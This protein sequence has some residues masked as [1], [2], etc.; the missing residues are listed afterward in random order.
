MS[1]RGAIV[2]VLALLVLAGCTSTAP[3]RER[4]KGALQSSRTTTD[5]LTR[6]T[7]PVVVAVGDIAC[8]PGDRVT[9]D[10]CRHARTARLA[11]SFDPDRLLLLGDL[12]YDSGT[13]AEFRRSYAS[14]W[15]EMRA[16]SRPVPGN[17]EYHTP[18]AE[19]YFYYFRN[20]VPSHPGYYVFRVGSW[21]VFALNSNC[22]V[23]DCERQQRWLNR[24]MARRATRCSAV[25]MHHPRY[26]SG[27][28]HGSTTV[29]RP[30]WKV[31]LD[32]RTD[33][34]LAGHDHG[35]ERFRRMNANGGVVRS[36]M[37]SFVSGA[38]GRSLYDFGKAESGSV[39]RDSHAAGVLVLRLGEGRYAWEYRT[40]D[41]RT[42]DSG[43]RRC[44]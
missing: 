26:S 5:A 2:A 39:V 25:M 32:H 21:R 16:R 27:E 44:V 19:G 6:V 11:A 38:G 28:E 41:G 18:R 40:I 4:E 37:L 29:V 10:K 13:L 43:V 12:Q 31:A 8:P 24:A 22:T 3:D 34:A 36:G 17:H 15:G 7:G 42:V 33:I 30:F 20:Q 23:V 9:S 35:Y 1:T 14:S